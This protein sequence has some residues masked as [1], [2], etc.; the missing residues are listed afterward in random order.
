MTVQR[1][2]A[3]GLTIFLFVLSFQNCSKLSQP[4]QFS[5]EGSKLNSDSTDSG[6]GYDGKIYVLLGAGCSDGSQVQSKI[7]LLSKSTAELL[8]AN[9][10]D[11]SPL[12]L[13][14][15]N[16]QFNATKNELLYNGATYVAAPL[17]TAPKLTNVVSPM[18]FGAKCDG[19]TDDSAAFQS[20]VNS[21]DVLVPANANC[22]INK[23]VMIQVS[24]K[25][26][27]CS[28]GATLLHTDA[29]AGRMFNIWPPSTS[30]TIDD[31]SFVGCGF[32]GANTDI[33]QYYADARN[34]E[35]AINVVNR[36]TNLLVAGNTFHNFYGDAVVQTFAATPADTGSGYKI[37]SNLFQSCGG[38]GALFN[39]TVSGYIGYNTAIDCNMG[40]ASNNASQAT[41]GNMIEY[42]KIT[43]I[44]GTGW[45]GYGTSVFLS[46]GTGSSEDYSQN[47]VRYNTV[48]G[49]S[50]ASGF[51][52]L[53]EPSKILQKANSTLI[54]A[55][56][57]G[58][59]CTDGCV[60]Q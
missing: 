16:F 25:H 18:D 1:G 15:S 19:V 14:A 39:G 43:A 46:G 3:L 57:I 26:I 6:Q 37:I 12:A 13:V 24:H 11:I 21:G 41:G 9:C 35:T 56:Y 7:R 40:I 51:H 32:H 31:I 20:A 22:V 50:S 5:S 60:I 10:Q 36:V 23:P 53:V 2:I 27:E 38:N 8:R 45:S 29:F 42:N 52:G 54:P 59:L 4:I 28:P 34:N 44:Y 33:P 48:S 58:N 47:I 17:Y 30:S 55:Q 49:Q